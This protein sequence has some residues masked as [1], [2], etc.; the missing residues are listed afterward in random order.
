MEAAQD[1]MVSAVGALAIRGIRRAFYGPSREARL[2]KKVWKVTL[3][4]I[5]IVYQAVRGNV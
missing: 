1:L 3:Q 5:C 2:A 4:P